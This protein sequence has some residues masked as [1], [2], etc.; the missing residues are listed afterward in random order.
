MVTVIRYNPTGDFNKKIGSVKEVK[1]YPS[2]K[3]GKKLMADDSFIHST[4]FKSGKIGFKS[5]LW[6]F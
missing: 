2:S 6:N 4:E 5:G 3:K 1:I